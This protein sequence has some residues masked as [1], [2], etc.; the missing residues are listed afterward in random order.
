MRTIAISFAHFASRFCQTLWNVRRVTL[1]TAL[2]VL[3]DGRK[4]VAD[5]QSVGVRVPS[6]RSYTNLLERC[7]MSIVSSVQWRDVYTPR[8]KNLRRSK[9]VKRKS[10][11]LH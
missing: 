6:T 4:K 7:L 8:P 2:I 10:I 11:L 1:L 3:K 5:A 9:P